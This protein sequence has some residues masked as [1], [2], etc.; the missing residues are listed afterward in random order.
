MCEV[1]QGAARSAGYIISR[2][3]AAQIL[4]RKLKIDMDIDQLLFNP[5][6]S[7]MFRSLNVYQIIPALVVQTRD[8]SDVSDVASQRRPPRRLASIERKIL[9]AAHELRGSPGQVLTTAAG[10]TRLVRVG[11]R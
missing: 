6:V 10:K 7:T 8:T 9:R 1:T 2:D 11:Y 5:N 3:A 4:E